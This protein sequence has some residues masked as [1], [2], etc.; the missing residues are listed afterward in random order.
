M[1]YFL[2]R[3][4][5]VAPLVSVSVSRPHGIKAYQ[6][7]GMGIDKLGR[8][9]GFRDKVQT[10]IM[11][12]HSGIDKLGRSVGFRDKVQTGIMQLH[13]GIQSIPYTI[14]DI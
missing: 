6:P 4:S 13:S 11:Q 9:V 3:S 14:S 2:G 10:G 1:S 12:L 8:S 5:F 7:L